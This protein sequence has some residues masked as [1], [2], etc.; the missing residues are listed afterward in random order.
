MDESSLTAFRKV[1]KHFKS[2]HAQGP[3]AVKQKKRQNRL[4]ATLGFG[5]NDAS[6]TSPNN[7]YPVLR[8]QGVLNLSG[9]GEESG[10]DEVVGAGWDVDQSDPSGSREIEEIEVEKLD[11]YAGEGSV[12]QTVK[13]YIIGDAQLRL[14]R[15]S[16]EE[17]TLPPNPL[18]LSTHYVLPPEFSLFGA[19]VQDPEQLVDS[20]AA[21][22]SSGTSTPTSEFPSTRPSVDYGRNE[23]DTPTSSV[24]NDSISI[25][26]RS[27][28][29]AISDKD[30]ANFRSSQRQLISNKPAHE[31]GY[32]AL[33]QKV[34]LWKGDLPSP[35]LRSK[36]VRKLM[37]N[38]LRW[39]N[40]GWWT[41]KAYDFTSP[42]PIPFPSLLAR[43]CQQIIRGIPWSDVFGAPSPSN[44]TEKCSRFTTIKPDHWQDWTKDY[45]PD[46]GIVNFYHLK[47]T[48]MGHVDRSDGD[49]IIMSG[50]SRTFYH[51]V[52]RIMEGTLPN[53]FKQKDGDDEVMQACKR[54]MA[55][56][57]ININAR[58]VFPV[59]FIRPDS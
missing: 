8:G 16:L 26:A 25:P 39:A 43:T 18:N 36:T 35:K 20:K 11:D 44:A 41:N 31:E 15:C 1:E 21:S 19:Y 17:Y 23:R 14:A 34:A 46:T 53:H 52:P 48:L 57:R 59:N 42:D 50:K 4:L 56:A 58:Q 10:E 51:G 55:S 6:T 12:K 28:S 45:K 32:E 7:D 9:A 37:E 47:D 33:K 3:E 22:A 54:F 49:V 29:P 30:S 13:G 27:H 5:T 40:L 38:E 24:A 2:R